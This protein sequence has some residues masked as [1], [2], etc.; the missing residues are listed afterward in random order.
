MDFIGFTIKDR[1]YAVRIDESV[2]IVKHPV[3][4]SVPGTFPAIVGMMSYHG[5]LVPVVDLSI[6]YNRTT[7]N[8]NHQYVLI[9][10]GDT[11]Y[12]ILVDTIDS[13]VRN[14][15]PG[16]FICLSTHDIE[17]TAKQKPGEDFGNNIELF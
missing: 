15:I 12:G 10:R 16:N 1:S 17:N 13:V 11:I 6:L 8:E 4:T 2:A 5:I 7:E 3:I 14:E 9:V